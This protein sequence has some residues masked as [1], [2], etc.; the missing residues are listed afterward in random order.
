[1]ATRDMSKREFESALLRRG[2]AKSVFGYW[3]IPESNTY[4]AAFS[5]AIINV[6]DNSVIDAGLNW[7]VILS[8]ILLVVICGQIRIGPEHFAVELFHLFSPC[9]LYLMTCFQAS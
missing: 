6:G 4:V 3:Q 1:M 5:S 8:P 7:A 2:F 9:L